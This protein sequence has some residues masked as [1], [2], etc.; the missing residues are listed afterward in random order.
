MD[1]N[2]RIAAWLRM[3]KLNMILHNKL[4]LPFYQVTWTQNTLNN[5]FVH[6]DKKSLES[7]LWEREVQ[8]NRGQINNV[9]QRIKAAQEDLLPSCELE[10][11]L[12]THQ[13]KS[14]A[15]TKKGMDLL[16]S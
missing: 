6:L 1:E 11:T 7:G 2:P 14:E 9:C 15:Q 10:L 12:E 5:K 13:L 16:S 8:D 4:P 3:V